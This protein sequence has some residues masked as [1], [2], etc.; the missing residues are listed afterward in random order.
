MKETLPSNGLPSGLRSSL[1]VY[2]LFLQWFAHCVVFLATFATILGQADRLGVG[3]LV[4]MSLALAGIL[5]AM[6]RLVG[7]RS[8]T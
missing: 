7:R 6:T 3:G 1:V 5:T 8:R 2:N 4:I